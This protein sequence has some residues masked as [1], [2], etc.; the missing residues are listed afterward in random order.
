MLTQ[1]QYQHWLS[2]HCMI[3]ADSVVIYYLNLKNHF[4]QLKNQLV[5]AALDLQFLVITAFYNLV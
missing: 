5:L 4:L 1:Q 2:Q 3:N